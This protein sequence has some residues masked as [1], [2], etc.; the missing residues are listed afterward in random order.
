MAIVRLHSDIG[1]ALFPAVTIHGV[2][3]ASLYDAVRATDEASVD[4]PNHTSKCVALARAVKATFRLDLGRP[5]HQRNQH[6]PPP[7]VPCGVELDD[8]TSMDGLLGA[9]Q[10]LRANGRPPIPARLG[11]GGSAPGGAAAATAT[12]VGQADADLDGGSGA[13]GDAVLSSGDM[14]PELLALLPR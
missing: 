5:R 2:N 13:G 4:N 6:Q 12:T 9:P 8:H 14:S 1:K 10:L 11:K 7:G 3:Y